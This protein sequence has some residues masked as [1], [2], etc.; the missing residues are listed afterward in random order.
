MATQYQVWLLDSQGNRIAVLPNEQIAKLTYTLTANA[1]GAMTL[2]VPRDAL[3]DAYVVRDAALEIWRKPDG[4]T[5]QREGNTQWL[6]TKQARGLS[7]GERYRRVAAEPLTTLL[8]RRYVMYSQN[9]SQTVKGGY[10]DTILKELFDENLGVHANNATTYG[11][12]LGNQTPSRRWDTYISC[13]PLLSQGITTGRSGLGYRNVL[14]VMQE[15]CRDSA[16]GSIPVY[17]DIICDTSTTFVFRTWAN[18]RGVDRSSG[19]SRLVVSAERGSLGGTIE[20]TDDWSDLVTWMVAGGGGQE[21]N[22]RIGSSWN[23]VLV[24][25]SRFGVIEG[26]MAET[27]VTDTTDLAADASS[28]LYA[29]AAATKRLTGDV[30]SVPGAIYGLDWGWGDRIVA[31]FEDDAFKAR[32]D[33]VTVTLDG[34]QETISAAIKAETSPYGFV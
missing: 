25:Q 34:G 32:L 29:R 8:S 6:V 24:G 22:R 27:S 12:F 19:S 33:T 21:L 20:L 10:P 18:V 28:E 13:D 17:F 15:V 23:D 11:V 1:V 5:L 2:T 9:G 16:N 3:P 26:F 30:V 31:E 7:K 4:G 14:S